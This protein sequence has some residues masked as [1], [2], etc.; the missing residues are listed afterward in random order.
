MEKIKYI[1]KFS[2]IIG[3]LVR[4]IGNDELRCLGLILNC[5]IRDLEIYVG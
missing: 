5:K 1:D 2:V 4:Y 3:Y